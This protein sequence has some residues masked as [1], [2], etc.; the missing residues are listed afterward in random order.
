MKELSKQRVKDGRD[1]QS[2]QKYESKKREQNPREVKKEKVTVLH[3]MCVSMVKNAKKRALFANRDFDLDIEFVEQKIY[4]FAKENACDI[5]LE[6][7]PF[8]PSIDRIDNT[9]GYTKDNVKICWLIENYCKNT[10]TDEDVI[11]FCRRKLKM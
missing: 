7:K 1:K 5:T 8:K 3:K 11:E 6:K 10:F 2:K 9:K 4:E